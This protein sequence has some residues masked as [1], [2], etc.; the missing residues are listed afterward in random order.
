MSKGSRQENSSMVGSSLIGIGI[1]QAQFFQRM[2]P[3]YILPRRG[4]QTCAG[5]VNLPSS[6]DC[7]HA[8]EQC[9]VGIAGVGKVN[10]MTL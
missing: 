5:D 2:L 1:Q 9:A 10:Q 6:R 8:F 3:A 7:H 4:R